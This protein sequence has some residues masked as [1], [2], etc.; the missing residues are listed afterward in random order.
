MDCI[1]LTIGQDGIAVLELNRPDVLNALNVPLLGEV[2]ETLAAMAGDERV[3]ALIITGRGRAFCAGADLGAGVLQGDEESPKSIGERVAG[4][5]A[6]EFNPMIEMVYTFPRPVITAVNGIAAGGGA[7]L[8]LCADIVLASESAA[9]KVV[10]P[11]Q[12][13]IAGDLGINWLLARIAGRSR[14]LGLCLLGDTIPAATLREWGLVWECVPAAALLERA[15]QIAL[16]L[17]GLPRETL[18]ATRSLVDTAPA[19]TFQQ[20]I[21]SERLRQQTLCDQPEFV[22]SVQRFFAR[23]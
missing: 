13:G 8:A 18:L 21:E 17:A 2:R 5:M 11:Q 6:R 16:R 22:E 20:S 1:S 9:L 19:H 23:R 12:L 4:Q 3:K 10:Q 15:R 7:G 14:A